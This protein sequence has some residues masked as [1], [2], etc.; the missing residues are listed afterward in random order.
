MSNK[1]IFGG[2]FDAYAKDTK[3]FCVIFQ[4]TQNAYI[5][6]FATKLPLMKYEYYENSKLNVIR[7]L[8]RSQ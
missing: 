8:V 4:I 6:A 7:R 2:N 1:H 3:I 5:F